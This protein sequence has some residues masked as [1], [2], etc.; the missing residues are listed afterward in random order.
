MEKRKL[1][2]LITVLSIFIVIYSTVMF[3][4]DYNLDVAKEDLSYLE[5]LGFKNHFYI[6][7]NQM[8][9]NQYGD[10][11]L[12]IDG[13]SI[14]GYQR[15]GTFYQDL[16]VTGFFYKDKSELSYSFDVF[17]KEIDESWKDFSYMISVTNIDD[18][19]KLHIVDQ[20][21]I[22]IFRQ[23]IKDVDPIVN[24]NYVSGFVSDT[25]EYKSF[26]IF[27]ET[28]YNMKNQ[29]G[30]YIEIETADYEEAYI[31]GNLLVEQFYDELWLTYYVP[32]T[33]ISISRYG[34]YDDIDYEISKGG[35][36][37]ESLYV[38]S[39]NVQ[40]E[41]LDRKFLDIIYEKMEYLDEEYKIAQTT[42]T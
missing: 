19:E 36:I 5:S 16:V 21:L 22:S 38:Y 7:D 26:D 13:N 15:S 14:Y 1:E 24:H 29:I 31:K 42:L 39:D 8:T 2:L 17:P 18:L 34:N 30:D 23:F 37:A 33:D 27:D 28:T 35:D 11:V 4:D 20:E 12:E 10:L 3:N 6:T 25:K 40:V 32:D 9:S 41:F